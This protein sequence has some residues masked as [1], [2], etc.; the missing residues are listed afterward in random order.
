[1]RAH[2]GI[3][4]RIH[5][6]RDFTDVKHLG[7]PQMEIIDSG[8]CIWHLTGKVED[9]NVSIEPI[10]CNRASIRQRYAL[11]AICLLSIPLFSLIIAGG[12]N[13]CVHRSSWYI[14]QPPIYPFHR[15][16]FRTELGNYGGSNRYIIP[17]YIAF[18][19]C[20]YVTCCSPKSSKVHHPFIQTN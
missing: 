20:I 15:L 8:G 14:K 9:G 3:I 6:I 2:S 12:I 17:C 18:S 5:A 13:P 7:H 11:L 10:I 4:C 19:K 1:M 16:H